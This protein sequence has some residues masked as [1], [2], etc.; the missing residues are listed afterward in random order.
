MRISVWLS[1]AVLVGACVARAAD[2]PAA[3]CARVK[4]RAAARATAGVVSCHAEAARGGGPVESGCLGQAAERLLT[5][6]TR[7]DTLGPCPTEGV[8]M[9]HTIEDLVAIDLRS[10]VS[11]T[12]ACP[13]GKL[14]AAGRKIAARL[15]C[16]LPDP[17][18]PAA[19]CFARADARFVAAFAR[20]ERH[21]P[22]AADAGTVESIADEIAG[23]VGGQ[24]VGVP[25]STT[26][27]TTTTLPGLCG[28]GRVDAGDQCDGQF[29]C[30]PDC[31]FGPTACCLF[32]RGG[33]PTTCI[34]F[35]PT[36]TNVLS[37]ISQGDVMAG[38]CRPDGTCENPAIGP[39]PVC[40][41]FWFGAC[42]TDVV[43]SIADLATIYLD[44]TFGGTPFGMGTCGVDRTCHAGE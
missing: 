37:C 13:A 6:F 8:P 24:I 40:T 1:V 7:A 39:F 34:G 23:S 33:P 27:T 36:R 12:G 10:T 19:A 15:R 21:G 16:R 29:F 17:A 44:G 2:D 18:A 5:A 25:P 9:Q 22:C 4:L 41:Q 38:V 28:N 20:A 35:L 30:S 14:A 32:P 26:S 43:S 11:G 3:R 42:R 31:T